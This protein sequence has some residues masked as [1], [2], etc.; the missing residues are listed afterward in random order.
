MT[1]P[2]NKKNLPTKPHEKEK[3]THGKAKSRLTTI[4]YADNWLD[5]PDLVKKDFETTQ[6]T[7]DY[8]GAIRL[9]C[10]KFLL[11]NNLPAS[12]M[13][14]AEIEY[15]KSHIAKIIEVQN[16]ETLSDEEKESFY[17]TENSKISKVLFSK[18][19]WTSIPIKEKRLGFGSASRT[20]SSFM[21]VIKD[22]CHD[23]LETLA[24]K[25]IEKIEITQTEQLFVTAESAKSARDLAL[26][27]I[28]ELF[29]LFKIYR[30]E[31]PKQ[32][33]KAKLPRA[34]AIDSIITEV[35]KRKQVTGQTAK[36]L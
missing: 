25:I 2:Y 18:A 9:V 31:I 15:P 24:A 34:D 33:S 23:D 35:A 26:L 20:L 14:Y 12:P 10:E 4:E 1:R 19:N 22:Y 29:T 8:L 5:Y 27:D 17:V 36:E 28:G 7:N 6:N 32:K 30:R 3:Y 11:E 16:D 21:M 13:V